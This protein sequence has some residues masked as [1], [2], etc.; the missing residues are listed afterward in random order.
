MFL[1]IYLLLTIWLRALNEEKK[2]NCLY[3]D[4]FV[5]LQKTI[6]YTY[7]SYSVFPKIPSHMNV[8]F[9]Y[10]QKFL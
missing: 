8:I 4:S 7:Y 9:K 10:L 3:C 1:S 6:F 5:V 2:N